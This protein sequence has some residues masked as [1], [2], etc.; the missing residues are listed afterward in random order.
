MAALTVA[1]TRPRVEIPPLAAMLT[2]AAFLC[3]NAQGLA[4]ARRWYE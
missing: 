2:R 4:V 3:P 1:A